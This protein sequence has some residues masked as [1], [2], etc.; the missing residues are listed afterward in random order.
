MKNFLFLF[1]IFSC[2]YSCHKV[3]TKTKET[4]QQ[5]EEIV[6]KTAT[7]S[8][9]AIGETAANFVDGV[10]LGIDQSKEIKISISQ[11]IIQ[12]G[13]SFGN[14]SIENDSLNHQENVL[15]LYTIFDKDFEGKIQVKIKNQDDQEIGRLAKEIQ[16]KAGNAEY[17]SFYFDPRTHIS[18]RS[19]IIIEPIF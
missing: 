9:E 11:D 10:G 2:I 16:G 5:G 3:K 17:I 6:T 4:L 15:I 14:F 7:K 8:G 18:K 12:K 19:N 13:V 1:L